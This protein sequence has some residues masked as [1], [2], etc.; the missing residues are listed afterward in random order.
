LMEGMGKS[1]F[2]I[3]VSSPEAQAFFNQGIS[4]LY[5]FWF[6]EAERSFMQVAELDPDAGMAYWGIAMSAAGDFRPMYQVYLNP[7]ASVPL[8]PVPGSGYS[9]SSDA[10]RKARLLQAKLTARERLYI[11]AIAA[12]HNP[13]TR[14][15][16]DDY[17][18]VMRSLVKAFP[19]DDNAK[20][21]LALAL[22][23]GYEPKTRD[24]RKGTEEGISLLKEVLA[25]NPDHVGAYHFFIH[26]LEDSGNAQD[27]WPA[28]EKYP[29]LVTGI[30]HALHMPGHIYIQSGRIE[31]ALR[32]FDIAGEK[33]QSYIAADPTYSREHYFHNQQFMIL[34]LGLLGQY[35]RAVDES[36]KLMAVPETPEEAATVDVGSSYRIG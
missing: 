34:T 21:I 33:E 13:R 15:P 23:R 20:T 31:E 6:T 9:R 2:P 25:K 11:D 24:P 35:R 32:A 28:A 14:R 36:R 17:A 5:A 29:K 22:L 3:T 12:R 7:N 4:Q 27:A 19:E 18:E 16:D 26:A 1:D 8:I 10:I 30:P